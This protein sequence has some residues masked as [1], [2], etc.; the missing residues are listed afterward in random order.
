MKPVDVGKVHHQVNEG[1]IEADRSRKSPSS[2][3]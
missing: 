2:S 1:Q 3:K